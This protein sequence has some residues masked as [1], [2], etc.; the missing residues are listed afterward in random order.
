MLKKRVKVLKQDLE[1]I[2]RIDGVVGIYTTPLYAQ[3]MTYIKKLLQQTDNPSRYERIETNIPDILFSNIVEHPTMKR[4]IDYYNSHYG[5]I[6]DRF[7]LNGVWLVK[8]SSVAH[9]LNVKKYF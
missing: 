2:A 9:K 8:E 3:L 4:Y 1:E 7:Q 5:Y 6:R